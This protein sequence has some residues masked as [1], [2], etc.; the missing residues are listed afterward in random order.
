MDDT[1]TTSEDTAGT[2]NV[3]T[4]DTDVD[5]DALTVTGQT[6]GAHGT[7]SCTT[8]GRLHLHAGGQLQRPGLASPTR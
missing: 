4:N 5:G 8:A 7:A 6:N 2:K 1:L 3:L